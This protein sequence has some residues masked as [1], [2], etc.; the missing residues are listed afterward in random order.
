MYGK[1]IGT[2]VI[3]RLQI[4]QNLSRKIASDTKSMEDFTKYFNSEV[5]PIQTK[6]DQNSELIIDAVKFI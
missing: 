1:D 6:F 3:W 4:C 2:E 5:R